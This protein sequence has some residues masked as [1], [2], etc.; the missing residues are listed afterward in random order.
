MYRYIIVI[1]EL[2]QQ[3]YECSDFYISKKNLAFHLIWRFKPLNYA[4]Y[5]IGFLFKK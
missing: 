3:H 2:R 4:I 1:I 5:V